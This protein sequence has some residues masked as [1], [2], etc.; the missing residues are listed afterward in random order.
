MIK[1]NL[2][3]Q[4][5][6][7]RVVSS[8]EKH[9]WVGVGALAAAAALTFV[10]VH[11]PKSKRLKQLETANA[12]MSADLNAKKQQ[13]VGYDE[14]KKSLEAAEKRSKA[15]EDLSAAAVV[16][17]HILHELGEILTP[18]K[19]P[20]MSE[21]MQQ[22]VGNGPM[23]DPNRRFAV[24]WDAQKVWITAFKDKNGEFELE[25]GAQND[26]DVTQLSKRLQA[27]VY[28]ENVTPAGAE[29]QADRDPTLTYY[30]FKITRK[31]VY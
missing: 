25:G 27:S 10:A 3:P 22:R 30:K 2:L 23:S 31:L 1:I 9:T 18:G 26:S 29:R 16:P 17:A 28:F 14:I 4:R 7:K 5:K 13:L 11:L 6:P 21:A 15:I 24:D 12:G 20:T 19:L 8:G